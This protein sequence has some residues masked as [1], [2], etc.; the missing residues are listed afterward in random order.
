MDALTPGGVAQA[1]ELNYPS[2]PVVL[3]AAVIQ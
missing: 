3:H 1:D 2:R